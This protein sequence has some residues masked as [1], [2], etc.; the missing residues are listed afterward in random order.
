MACRDKLGSAGSLSADDPD[1]RDHPIVG[2]Q[3]TERRH[4]KETSKTR[5]LSAGFGPLDVPS[6]VMVGSPNLGIG[7]LNGG[8]GKDYSGPA[9][10]CS[11]I[12]LQCLF[13]I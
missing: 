12:P 6:P 7:F 8:L 9:P 4:L 3:I 5:A 2:V 13:L 1:T 11:P 10:A